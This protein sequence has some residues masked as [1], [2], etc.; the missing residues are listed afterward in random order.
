MPTRTER[1]T[2]DALAAY[3]AHLRTERHVSPHTLRAYLADLRQFLAFAGAG[4]LAAVR[5]ETIRHWLRALDGRADRSS[6]A[7]TACNTSP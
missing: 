3:A 2:A 5:I 7:R 4:G 6:I 1:A